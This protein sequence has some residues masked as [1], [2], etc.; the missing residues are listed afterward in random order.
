MPEVSAP[1]ATSVAA[2]TTEKA[3]GR[4]GG[5]GGRDPRWDPVI[6]GLS[7]WRSKDGATIWSYLKWKIK[8]LRIK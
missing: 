7:D 1:C 3:E 6:T 2:I 4:S 8:N 5:G